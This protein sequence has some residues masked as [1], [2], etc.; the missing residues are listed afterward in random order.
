MQLCML[1]CMNNVLQAKLEVEQALQKE[2]RCRKLA[3]PLTA[4]SAAKSRL[5]VRKETIR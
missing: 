4:G 1:L 3:V 2:G 5:L